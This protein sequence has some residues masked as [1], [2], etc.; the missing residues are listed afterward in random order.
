MLRTG[1]LS[2]AANVLTSRATILHVNK[3][4][5]FQLNGL[6]SY[7]WIWQRFCDSDLKRASVR[8]AYCLSKDSPKWD[9]QSQDIACQCERLFPT[10]LIW[11]WSMNMINVLWCRFQQCLGAFTILL[12]KG[13]SEAWLFRHLSDYVFRVQKFGNT[14]SMTVIFCFKIFKIQSRFQNWSQKLKKSVLFVR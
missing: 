4:D 2:S 3:R 5:F 7:Q 14:K 8:L 1:Y 9:K 12:V 10:Q 13:S 6:R 11:Q